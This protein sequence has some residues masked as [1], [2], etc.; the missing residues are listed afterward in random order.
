M[1]KRDMRLYFDDIL[2]ALAK[3]EQFIAG[4]SL[5]EFR[6]DPKTQDAV[7]R[8][9]EIIGEAVKRIP[10]DLKTAHTE[11]PWRSAGDMRDFLIHDYPD[12]AADVVWKTATDDLPEFQKRIKELLENLSNS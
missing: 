2:K 12:I 11:I 6:K 8:N 1:T 9:F 10:E 7:I 5:E 3:I 4:M